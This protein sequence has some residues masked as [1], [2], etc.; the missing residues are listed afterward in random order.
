[1][2]NKFSKTSQRRLDTCHSD[3]QLLMNVVLQNRDCSILCGH[4]TEEEQN[5][6]V[7]GGASKT[8]FPN[9]KHNAFPSNAVDIQQYPYGG[10]VKGLYMFIGYVQRVAEELGIKIRCGADWDSDGS[11]KDQT[12]H[13]VFHIELL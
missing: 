13:D 1:M 11:T 10:D 6:A 8:V 7:A 2:A 12:F 4:R 3:L 9:S 5:K